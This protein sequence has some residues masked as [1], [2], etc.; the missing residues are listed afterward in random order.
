MS[1]LLIA[2]LGGLLALDNVSV[3][4]TM[5]S[6]PLPVGFLVG[7][8]LGDPLTGTQVGALLELYLLVVVPAGGGRNPEGSVA[9]AVGVSAAVLAPGLTGLVFGVTGGL[10]WGWLAGFTQ[11]VMRR[12]ND[13]RVPVPGETPITEA[14]I[15]EAQVRGIVVDFLRSF[16]LVL[17]GVLLARLLVPLLVDAWWLEDGWTAGLLVGGGMVSAGVMVRAL[18]QKRRNDWALVLASALIG[19]WIAGGAG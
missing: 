11:S 1:L 5:V 4:Q 19:W 3:G 9:T 7:L 14:A 8:L 17:V 15:A 2:L 13:L 12:S 10:I 16:T 6:R 18:A